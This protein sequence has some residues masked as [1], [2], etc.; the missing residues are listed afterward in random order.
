MWKKL[1]SKPSVLARHINAPYREERERYLEHCAHQGYTRG[2]LL[3]LAKELFWVARKVP[4]S[5]EHGVTME[6]VKAAAQGWSQRQRYCSQKLNT[7]WTRT[8][9]IQVA[10]QWLRFL[11]YLDDFKKPM[12]FEHLVDD[13]RAWMD[14]QRGF[15]P[16]TIRHLCGKA[17]QFLLWFA[18]L[19]RPF[20]TVCL[21][22]IDTFLISCGA[23][24]CCR[25]SVKNTA[26]TLRA[27]FKYAGS[28][29]WC[30]S[31]IALGIQGPRVFS[32]EQVPSGPSWHD[33]NRLIASVQ[34][35]KKSDIRDSAIIL[36]FA[37]YG[38]RSFEVST[39]GLDGIDWEHNL[40][41]ISRAKRREKQ[42]YPLI[43]P[44]GE[45]IIR[46]L[47]EV[48]PPCSRREL[49]L[50]LTPPFRPISR[51]GLYHVTS[52][53]M[54]A[55]NIQSKRYGPHSLRHACAARLVSEGLSLKEIG[56]H[57]GHRSASATR[58]YAKV[59]LPGLR[60]VATFDLGGLL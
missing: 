12:P 4:I 9:F 18:N 57:L 53:R 27:F 28:N 32:E 1:F 23:K 49:F 30:S 51:G 7:R 2:T 44:V 36:L 45:A 39:L 22:D 48:R 15:T 47:C 38:F 35:D 24:G 8:R 46:Y 54:M 33:V 58:I 19:D 31:S 10:R 43:R 20:S 56:D 34:T 16:A 50:T 14:E 26:T 21:S 6:R 52:T 60:E 25:K 17:R 37:V 42:T 11:G 41:S 40:I 29:G 3:L 55:L 13:F 5:P 59:D